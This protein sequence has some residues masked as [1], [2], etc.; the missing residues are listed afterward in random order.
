MSVSEN[1]QV[2]GPTAVPER[3]ATLEDV[4]RLAGVSRQTVSNAVNA[5]HLLRAAT[6]A[7]VAAAADRLDY[8]PNAAARAMRTG[9]AGVLAAR[10]GSPDLERSQRV[11]ASETFL[12]AFAAAAHGR[13]RA[14]VAVTA[15][16][17]ET[18]ARRY[19]DLVS[20]LGLDGVL[21]G[22][23]GDPCEVAATDPRL[24]WLASR[25]VR[26]VLVGPGD[27]GAGGP[28]PR[29]DVDLAA[30]FRAATTR[31]V[32]LGHRRIAL[33]GPGVHEEPMYIASGWTS[34]MTAA[35]LPTD[36]LAVATAPDLGAVRAAVAR[37]LARPARPSAL[38]CTTAPAAAAAHAE[39][40]AWGLTVGEDIALVGAGEGLA[41]HALDIATLAV[42]ATT[43]AEACVDLLLRRPPVADDAA[44]PGTPPVVHLVPELTARR[45]L[46]A[47]SGRAGY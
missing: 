37:V 6:L 28:L 13:G 15:D 27:G 4:A 23:D 47:P 12:P 34:A 20:G 44:G 8:R 7:R 25:R 41:L 39:I 30:G 29:V 21:V 38:V 43:L 24:T 32:E 16:D 11:T 17:D 5:P 35:G 42:P 14:V 18:E 19:T 2:F 31:L 33:V 22:H 26:G 10:I 36:D 1:V 46:E 40:V 3:P 9:Q 45:S